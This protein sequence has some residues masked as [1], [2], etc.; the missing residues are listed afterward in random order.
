MAEAFLNL[1]CCKNEEIEIEIEVVAGR[2]EERKMN[3]LNGKRGRSERLGR[4]RAS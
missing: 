1:L 4:R 2:E 3:P